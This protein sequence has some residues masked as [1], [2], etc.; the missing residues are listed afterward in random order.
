M[1]PLNVIVEAAANVD[2][3][4]RLVLKWKNEVAPNAGVPSRILPGEKP[5]PKLEPYEGSRKVL[6]TTLP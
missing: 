1:Q 6:F 3:F 5:P 2:A 4:Q